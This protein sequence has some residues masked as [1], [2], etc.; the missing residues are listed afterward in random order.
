MLYWKQL[1][2]CT[3]VNFAVS[4]ELLSN[5]MQNLVYLQ[6]KKHFHGQEVSTFCDNQRSVT[7]LKKKNIES[8]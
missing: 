6:A 8:K 7:N 1:P 2:N 3:T 4:V 5:V